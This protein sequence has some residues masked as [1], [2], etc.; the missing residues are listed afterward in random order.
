MLDYFKLILHKV[1]FNKDLFEKELSKALKALVP[2]DVEKLREWCYQK[3]Q[4]LYGEILNR[5][6]AQLSA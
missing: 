1:S 3:F 5:Y 6:F 4:H 2:Q